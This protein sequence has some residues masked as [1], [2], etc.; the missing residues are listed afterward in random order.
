MFDQAVERPYSRRGLSKR[1]WARMLS[2]YVAG[3]VV[4]ILWFHH[5]ADQDQ[6]L[7]SREKIVSGKILEI[8]KGRS[9]SARYTFQFQGTA[10]QGSDD[11][12]YLDLT[13][14][15]TAKI[16]IDPLHPDEDKLRSFRFEHSL[17]HGFM[18]LLIFISVVLTIPAAVLWVQ[19]IG[20]N[21]GRDR[22][23]AA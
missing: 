21:A 9:D 6:Q 17:H 5:R 15:S 7:A 1:G 10:Y 3:C 18:T 14:G 12:D 20:Q 16:F 22:N 11:C 23:G 19:L 2:I 13:V 4:L 8:Q